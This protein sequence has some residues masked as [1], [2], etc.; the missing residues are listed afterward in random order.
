MR[1]ATSSNYEDIRVDQRSSTTSE[2]VQLLREQASLRPT[3]PGLGIG[4]TSLIML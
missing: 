4:N 2:L 3:R 1:I